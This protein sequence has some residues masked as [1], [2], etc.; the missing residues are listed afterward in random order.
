MLALAICEVQVP[1]LKSSNESSA[2]LKQLVEVG[3][4]EW[5]GQGAL[6]GVANPKSAVFPGPV[7]IPLRDLWSSSPAG[8][9]TIHSLKLF[10][11]LLTLHYLH[12]GKVSLF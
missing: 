4:G 5:V 7:R 12:Y 3:Y 9:K 11:G 8:K 1:K 2:T 10:Y 6:P